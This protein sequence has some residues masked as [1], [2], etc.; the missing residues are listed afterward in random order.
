MAT[1]PAAAKA[2]QR[3]QLAALVRVALEAAK[4]AAAE[5]KARASAAAIE[6]A[7]AV[8]RPPTQ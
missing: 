2:A 5:N 7:D 4:A 3:E 6:T 8:V 1:I